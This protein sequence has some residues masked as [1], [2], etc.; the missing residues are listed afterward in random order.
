MI[1]QG[2]VAG[3]DEARLPRVT[4][5]QRNTLAIVRVTQNGRRYGVTPW[6]LAA[7][8]EISDVVAA[9]QLRILRQKEL[10]CYGGDLR[11]AT[12][13]APHQITDLGRDVLANPRDY[14]DS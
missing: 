12:D 14:V 4:I 10:D 7:K 1:A 9:R 13:A 8:L 11:V 6:E 2:D 3:S 5:D